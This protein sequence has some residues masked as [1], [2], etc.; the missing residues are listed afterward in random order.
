MLAM[1]GHVRCGCSLLTTRSSSAAA[2]VDGHQ[3]V[4]LAQKLNPDIILMDISMPILDGID[5]TREIRRLLPSAYVV[6]LSQYEIP[7]VMEEALSAGASAHVSKVV[8]WTQLIPTL[9]KVYRGE[10][11]ANLDADSA[12]GF[13]ESARR[14]ALLEAAVRESEERFRCTFELSAV[15]IAHV[16][17]DGHWLRVNRRLCEILGYQKDELEKLNIFGLIYPADRATDFAQGQKLL[18]GEIDQYSLDLRYLRRDRKVAWVRS[19]V[20]AVRDAGGNLK[21]SI[22]AVEDVADR[23][24]AQEQL[25]LAK[26]DF[27]IATDHLDLVGSHTRAALTRCSRDLRYLWANQNYADWLQKPLETIIGRP[28]YEVVG[29]QAFRALRPRF[30]QVLSGEEVRYKENVVFEGIGP[31]SISAIYKP[32]LDNTGIP[33]GWLAVVQ[34]IT[35]QPGVL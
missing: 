13:G 19:H 11:V 27:Q 20:H 15:G 30:Q 24:E 22:R 14:R 31:R 6:T 5:A 12:T 17:Q 3:A 4:L 32:T 23:K 8:V 16:D 26:R 33:D 35:P 10:A 28:I 9:R 2:A 34:D 25:A 18:A 29:K 7:D 21:Y 1:R